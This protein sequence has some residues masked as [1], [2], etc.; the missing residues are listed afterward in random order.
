MGTSSTKYDETQ[1]PGLQILWK[2]ILFPKQSSSK[3]EELN[4]IENLNM[5]S[6]IRKSKILSSLA[7]LAG[8]SVGGLTGASSSVN[9][10]AKPAPVT[11]NFDGSRVSPQIAS[12]Y[13]SY[14]YMPHPYIFAT[15]FGLYSVLSPLGLHT[16]PG[17]QNDLQVLNSIGT[18]KPTDLSNNDEYVEEA[19]KVEDVKPSNTVP[20][21]TTESSSSENNRNV[22]EKMLKTGT[23]CSEQK[24]FKK[25]Q[26]NLS[27][28]SS[29]ERENVEDI[30]L[31][32]RQTNTTR[33]NA[34]STNTTISGNGTIPTMNN[35]VNS[36][37]INETT[38]PPFYGY[39]GGYPQNIDHIDFTTESNDYKY[40][41]YESINYNLPYDKAANL[42]SDDRYNYYVNPSLD[43]SVPN[44]FSR[45]QI[46]EYFPYDFNRYLYTS[47]NTPPLE[48]SGFRPVA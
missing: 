43:S 1:T 41:N 9:T 33:Q 31:S 27:R 28:D 13:G 5:N 45:E 34:T 3:T 22:E 16:A 32:F 23:P 48:N 25:K 18:K 39:Y 4:K 30:V 47:Y 15:P 36:T 14:P 38:I 20:E 10:Y 35:M 2:N 8:L 40:H 44:E 26:D 24:G 37:Q 11:L 46:P 17:F 7:F 12:I 6:P 42:Y 19:K 21:E 29:K